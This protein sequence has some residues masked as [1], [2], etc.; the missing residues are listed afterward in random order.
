MS[1]AEVGTSHSKPEVEGKIFTKRGQLSTL[2]GGYLM[3][4][5]QEKLACR[6]P[7]WR[8]RSRVVGLGWGF[9]MPPNRKM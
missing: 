6:H 1:R 2:F 4:K 7:P 3:G 9:A 8:A 5:Q